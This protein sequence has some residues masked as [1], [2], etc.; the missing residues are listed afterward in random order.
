MRVRICSSI[1]SINYRI[2]NCLHILICRSASVIFSRMSQ[3][4]FQSLIVYKCMR[5][6]S[7]TVKTDILRQLIFFRETRVVDLYDLI[8]MRWSLISTIWSRSARSLQI[9][10]QVCFFKRFPTC[11]HRKKKVSRFLSSSC[12][13]DT[14]SLLIVVGSD[15]SKSRVSFFF[16]S[17]DPFDVCSSRGHPTI[18][19]DHQSP[20]LRRPMTAPVAR[21]YRILFRTTTPSRILQSRQHENKFKFEN[22]RVII[23]AFRLTV[24]YYVWTKM[25]YVSS[26]LADI[27][28]QD[29]RLD[30]E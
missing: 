28:L 26:S 15:L 27:I 6:A 5:D 10:I 25:K 30:H 7:A 21:P 14:T 4:V 18:L 8:S 19:P 20:W 17:A 3:D 9:R 12:M 16:F 1:I 23:D 24:Q 11:R 2:N 29:D 22:G 13:S